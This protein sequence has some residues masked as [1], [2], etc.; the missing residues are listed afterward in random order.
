MNSNENGDRME[1]IENKFRKMSPLDR[2]HFFIKLAQEESK[3][4]TSYYLSQNEGLES[5]Q[6]MAAELQDVSN[7]LETLLELNSQNYEALGDKGVL[8]WKTLLVIALSIE[9][10][11][12][13]LY[14]QNQIEERNVD[15][16]SKNQSKFVNPS[17]SNITQAQNLIVLNSNAKPQSLF[18]RL[19]NLFPPLSRRAYTGQK[20]PINSSNNI[21]RKLLSVNEEEE[22]QSESKRDV[23]LSLE[24]QIQSHPIDRK[25]KIF[26]ALFG[27]DYKIT[28]ED[29]DL[30][31]KIPIFDP[32]GSITKEEY[33]K[34]SFD[35]IFKLTAKAF[36]GKNSAI[37]FNNAKNINNYK[38]QT[39]CKARI[40][41]REDPDRNKNTED[42]SGTLHEHLDM[43]SIAEIVENET[44]ELSLNF[45]ADPRPEEML[46]SNFDRL[47]NTRVITSEQR[48]TLNSLLFIL[49]E[50]TMI[51][52]NTVLE[53][54]ALI[55]FY[56]DGSMRLEGHDIVYF[57]IANAVVELNRYSGAEWN[58][59]EARSARE[60][61]ITQIRHGI[62][63][64]IRDFQFLNLHYDTPTL[65]TFYADATRQWNQFARILWYLCDPTEANN[66]VAQENAARIFDLILEAN[67][68]EMTSYICFI[69]NFISL[70]DVN[71]QEAYDSVRMEMSQ[72]SN[73][74]KFRWMQLISSSILN[75]LSMLIDTENPFSGINLYTAIFLERINSSSEETLRR[76]FLRVTEFAGIV[77]RRFGNIGLPFRNSETENLINNIASNVPQITDRGNSDRQ[78]NLG[79]RIMQ[80]MQDAYNIFHVA[81]ESSIAESR[82]IF[83]NE[84]NLAPEVYIEY[85]TRNQIAQNLES[86]YDLQINTS[87]IQILEDS[88]FLSAAQNATVST[89]AMSENPLH[90]V[91]LNTEDENDRTNS[92][93]IIISRSGFN[94]LNDC[95]NNR[96]AQKSIEGNCD[97]FK[98][99]FIKNVGSSLS[100]IYDSRE[101]NVFPETERMNK[102]T[103]KEMHSQVEYYITDLQSSF[104]SVT[105]KINI[106][107]PIARKIAELANIPLSEIGIDP[108]EGKPYKNNLQYNVDAFRTK[109]AKKIEDEIEVTYKLQKKKKLFLIKPWVQAVFD[110]N[111]G[112]NSEFGIFNYK[113]Y[114]N[115]VK[116]NLQSVNERIKNPQHL[117]ELIFR[118]I[119]IPLFSTTLTIDNK[120]KIFE[121]YE[122]NPKLREQLFNM[123]KCLKK[124][125]HPIGISWF[126]AND[127]TNKGAKLIVPNSV[128]EKFNKMAQYYVTVKQNR[129]A[130]ELEREKSDLEAIEFFSTFN[131]IFDSI[132]QFTNQPIKD[133]E[134]I[135]L[136]NDLDITEFK[137]FQYIVENKGRIIYKNG[138]LEAISYSEMVIRE[139]LDSSFS[140]EGKQKILDYLK[141]DPLLTKEIMNLIEDKPEIEINSRHVLFMGDMLYISFDK[142][143][144][145]VEPNLKYC[146]DIYQGIRENSGNNPSGN[147]PNSDLSNNAN[148]PYCNIKAPFPSQYSAEKCGVPEDRFVCTTIKD[149]KKGTVYRYAKSDNTS[150]LNQIFRKDCS[151]LARDR[152]AEYPLTLNL[153]NC[154]PE[155][156]D[157][158]EFSLTQGNQKIASCKAKEG[159]IKCEYNND[160]QIRG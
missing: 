102:H 58:E 104:L 143:R 139:K 53:N 18:E 50:D 12:I 27:K 3:R 96:R 106:A 152:V 33:L 59:A 92:N 38:L 84:P 36:K 14:A 49:D 48:N 40:K 60:D 4:I 22:E 26:N 109:L 68:Y 31:N 66:P 21:G 91:L 80:N 32:N 129:R 117:K 7:K 127:T 52:L 111:L 148:N 107:Y 95:Y 6:K 128:H 144:E 24:T 105:G 157:L 132:K 125:Q 89:L 43:L 113:E 70:Q 44:Q 99:N 140:E 101:K 11:G 73:Q 146:Q 28:D 136:I 133:D 158:P 5:A 108:L 85:D 130:N 115:M 30:Y 41:K 10:Q 62:Y 110:S 159:Q 25:T 124:G 150:P 119:I 87:D 116:D 114:N 47:M 65:I 54:T 75:E 86:F 23:Q 16:F 138:K 137:K 154:F 77:L 97:E 55:R 72:L 145:N 112:L 57:F 64:Y 149:A 61:I 42:E 155:E 147:N 45:N 13:K 88:A 29:I 134:I 20:L 120:I 76:S 19:K 15:Q 79:T 141:T 156:K 98:W 1:R 126:K 160:N 63:R 82:M 34:K 39:T 121:Y 9:S 83:A 94:N 17:A 74:R 122:K 103:E 142:L 131:S 93:T 2:K 123:L 78:N 153:M 90:S 35:L 151:L 56:S 67:S 135:N 8:N 69:V 37:A 71:Y 51:D 118:E 100:G 81:V 46:S